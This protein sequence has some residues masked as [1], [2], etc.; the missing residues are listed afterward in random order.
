M[1]GV[2]SCDPR[3][4][5]DFAACARARCCFAPLPVHDGERRVLYGSWC[6]SVCVP[7]SCVGVH[8]LS[9]SVSGRGGACSVHLSLVLLRCVRACGCATGG[10]E[11]GERVIMLCVVRM[12]AC[13]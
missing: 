9:C 6:V 8:A 1:G 11:S 4:R 5:A 3:R 7:Q 12:T 2:W 13:M 10:C